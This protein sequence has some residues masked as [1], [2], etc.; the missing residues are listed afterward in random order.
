MVTLR[1]LFFLIILNTVFSCS[2]VDPEVMLKEIIGKDDL[3]EFNYNCYFLKRYS[4]CYTAY[5]KIDIDSLYYA[6][7][8]S[9]INC[10]DYYN[11][12]KNIEFESFYAK[13]GY[14]NDFEISDIPS[15]FDTKSNHVDIVG[16]YDAK[17][18]KIN[19]CSDF[20]NTVAFMH[21]F[22]GN[23]YIILEY[24]RQSSQQPSLNK[25]E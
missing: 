16:F 24:V 10:W 9:K 15:W 4:F 5:Y 21:Y 11:V 3:S 23:C 1:N 18:N 14:Y 22:D 7:L 2:S 12:P 6:D 20:S 25:N 13:N 19:R 8:K 17:N